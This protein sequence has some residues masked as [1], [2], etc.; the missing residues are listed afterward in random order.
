MGALLD[1]AASVGALSAAW[2]RVLANDAADDLLSPGVRHFA[3]QADHALVEL[4]R[5]LLPATID[6]GDSPK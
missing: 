3:E 4:S 2:E 5:Q 1:S 6:R